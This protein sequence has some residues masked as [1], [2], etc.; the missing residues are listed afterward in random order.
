MIPNLCT[1]NIPMA[2]V[3]KAHL[4]ILSQGGWTGKVSANC[5]E[6]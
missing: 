5:K 6:K 1:F 3:L 2:I 4:H